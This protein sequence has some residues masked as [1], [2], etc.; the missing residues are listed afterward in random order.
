MVFMLFSMVFMLFS[1]VF[2]LFFMVFMLFSY[3]FHAIFLW[4]SCLNVGIRSFHKWLDFRC[5]MRAIIDL[6]VNGTIGI[7]CVLYLVHFSP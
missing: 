7:I 2:M 4:F 5:P 1:I 6:L 3:G